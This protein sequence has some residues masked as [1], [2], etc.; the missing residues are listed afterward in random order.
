M[1]YVE[2]NP[3][4]H[5]NLFSKLLEGMDHSLHVERFHFRTRK[6]ERSALTRNASEAVFI[7]STLIIQNVVNIVKFEGF[8]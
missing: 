7:R 1:I 8:V 2:N 4:W 6:Q 5:L 3:V